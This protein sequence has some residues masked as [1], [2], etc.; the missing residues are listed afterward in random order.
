M[1]TNEKL[2][3]ITIDSIKNK[4]YEIR[5]QRVMLDSDLATL[6]QVETKRLKESVKRNIERFPIDAMFQ[7]TETEFT[8]LR[9]NFA[10]SNKRGGNRYLPFAFT[11]L[12]VSMLSSILSSKIAIQV[13]LQIMRTFIFLKQYYTTANKSESKLKRPIIPIISEHK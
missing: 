2:Q 6:Y 12:G 11:E 7:L 13:N 3:P 4:I 1:N 9:S 5:G 10:T 8:N